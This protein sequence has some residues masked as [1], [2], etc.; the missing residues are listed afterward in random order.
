L[1][2]ELLDYIKRFI[3][4]QLEESTGWYSSSRE[5]GFS[6][7]NMLLRPTSK[8]NKDILYLL[9]YDDRVEIAKIYLEKWIQSYIGGNGFT[10]HSGDY[11]KYSNTNEFRSI[12][13]LNGYDCYLDIESRDDKDFPNKWT[14]K[15][16]IF[17][18]MLLDVLYKKWDEIID[19]S[20]EKQL[21]VEHIFRTQLNGVW[22]Y[23]NRYG[24]NF[25]KVYLEFLKERGYKINIFDIFK[26]KIEKI[27]SNIN[28]GTSHYT[29]SYLFEAL[30]ITFDFYMAIL[31]LYGENNPKVVSKLQN[32]LNY[33][34]KEKLNVEKLGF[35]NTFL[36]TRRY[37]DKN[38][39][40]DNDVVYF[41]NEMYNENMNPTLKKIFL[42]AFINTWNKSPIP[43]VRNSIQLLV[44]L[45]MYKFGIGR[46]YNKGFPYNNQ[47]IFY[48]DI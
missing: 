43:K 35:M 5:V 40:G 13:H 48:T 18:Q 29:K 19:N 47:N 41:W 44:N 11:G 27:I 14:T 21:C 22:L 38:R 23:Y 8:T 46:N 24:Q 32:T 33:F 12:V 17:H 28:Q 25:L 16:E 4:I 6:K 42:N 15:N 7:V 39:E 37:D 30:I 20:P 26:K 31:D 2:K 3:E 9:P 45:S 34:F 36:Y 10:Y 1:D